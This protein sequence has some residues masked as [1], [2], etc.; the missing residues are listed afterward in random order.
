MAGWSLAQINIASGLAPMD[1]PLLADF[2]A[3]LDPINALAE[4]QPGFVWRLKGEGNDALS[5][6]V[7]DDPTIIV[8]MS[9]WRDMEA[10]AAFVYRTGH[11]HIMRRRKEWF[12]PLDPVFALWW[13]P[14]GHAPTPEEGKARL[15]HLAAH[16]PT[17]TA[18]TFRDPF[19]APDGEPVR[20]VLESCE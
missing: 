20:P 11:R 2:V 12:S 14:A 15:A 18:F 1:D 19:P 10:L 16:G 17:A 6:R 3:N 7:F 9:V 5:L 13:V 8:N 4:A